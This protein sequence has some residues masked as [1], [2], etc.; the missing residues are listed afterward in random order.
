MIRPQTIS[1]SAA[2]AS[3]DASFASNALSTAVSGASSLVQVRAGIIH[4]KRTELRIVR[5]RGECVSIREKV[6]VAA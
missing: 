3:K 4:G 5:D 6:N 2:T 1:S